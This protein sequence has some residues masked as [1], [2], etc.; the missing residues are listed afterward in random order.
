MR[1]RFFTVYL[2]RL[3]FKRPFAHASITR[4]ESE[5]VLVCCRLVDGTE[6]WGEGVPRSYV[7]GETPAGCFAQLAATNF[8]EQF[9]MDCESWLDVIRLCD[10][11]KLASVG[12]DPRGSYG[13]A[14][15]C[16]IETSILDAYGRLFGQPVS[17]VTGYFALATPI[18]ANHSS[19]RYS[20]PIDAGSPRKVR[21]QAILMRLYGFRNCKV[22]VGA[23]GD[24]DVARLRAIR[25]WSGRHIDLRIDVNEA[26]RP[27]EVCQK[28]ERLKPFRISCVEQ[29]VSHAEVKTL[30]AL[31]LR[32]GMPIMLDESLTSEQDAQRAIED[33]TCD[34][35]NIRLSKCGGFLRSLQLARLA[36]DARP[37]LSTWLPPRRIGNP[38]GGWPALGN[39]GSRHSPL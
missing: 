11:F 14:L 1:I 19:I 27:A 9:A 7:T 31:R 8:F 3:P 26:W 15:R 17:A 12:D 29:P 22:K 34:L 25:R 21:R 38:L 39:F 37:G 10:G 5:N 4:Q 24:D 35:F 28:L 2:I 16:A 33:K 30:S 36:H 23:P 13:N 32:L 6:G 20:A 18:R